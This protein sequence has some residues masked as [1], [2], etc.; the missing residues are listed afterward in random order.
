[1]F[2]WGFAIPGGVKAFENDGVFQKLMSSERHIE[3][4]HDAHLVHKGFDCMEASL[5]SWGGKFM[6][7]VAPWI[8]FPSLVVIVVVWAVRSDWIRFVETLIL[9]GLYTWASIWVRRR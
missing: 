7:R 2:G 8:V 5:D 6:D 9:L 4:P 1:M 3:D